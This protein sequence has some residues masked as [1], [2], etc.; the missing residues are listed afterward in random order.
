MRK[1]Y[2]FCKNYNRL[3]NHHNLLQRCL[4]GL[5][6]QP[7]KP[8]GGNHRGVIVHAMLGIVD[9]PPATKRR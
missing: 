3:F 7:T 2:K 4:V 6:V 1:N 5:V 8:G 9:Y